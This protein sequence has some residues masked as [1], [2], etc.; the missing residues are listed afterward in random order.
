MQLDGAYTHAQ[1]RGASEKG[2]RVLWPGSSLVSRTDKVLR[3][4][5]S[6]PTKKVKNRHLNSPSQGLNVHFQPSSNVSKET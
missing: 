5:S 2:S 4:S 3:N 6:T 1:K